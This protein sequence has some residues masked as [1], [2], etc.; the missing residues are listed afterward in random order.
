MKIRKIQGIIISSLFMVG[1]AGCSNSSSW[2][3]GD[4][5]PWKSKRDAE[6]ANAPSEEF[7]E[8]SLDEAVEVNSMEDAPIVEE[9]M[10]ESTMLEAEMVA[11]PELES[12]SDFDAEPVPVEEMS[13]FEKLELEAEP[14]MV[15]IETV[16]EEPSV[17]AVATDIM[18]A[19]ST[20][21][22]VQVYAGRVLANVNRYQN[23][24]ALDDMQIVKTDHDGDIIHV[25][26]G[27][28]D[29]YQTAVRAAM[30]IEQ[31]TG[32]TPWVRSVSGLQSMS[33]E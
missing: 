5:S 8:V 7:V 2:N 21:Y 31:S 9:A 1:L 3:Q 33:V 6:M 15:A 23:S 25:L 30:D 17:S 26:V 20:A 13:A 10:A 16:E 19:S 4:S 27:V 11:E 29:D 18:G 14:E 28:Y 32:S 22:A 24:H 12:I